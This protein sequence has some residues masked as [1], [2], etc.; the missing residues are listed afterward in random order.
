M[1]KYLVEFDDERQVLSEEELIEF[2]KIAV[3]NN[4]DIASYTVS[5]IEDVYV[6]EHGNAE[7]VLANHVFAV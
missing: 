5:R 6:D 3:V 7:Y 1:E 2:T 4:K